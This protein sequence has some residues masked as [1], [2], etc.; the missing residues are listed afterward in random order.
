MDVF[1]KQMKERSGKKK[2]RKETFRLEFQNRK[3]IH[4]KEAAL[5]SSSVFFSVFLPSMRG[6]SSLTASFSF[7][8]LTSAV[9][10]KTRSLVD[11]FEEEEASQRKRLVL[12]FLQQ[13]SRPP[14]RPFVTEWL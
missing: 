2:E 13:E 12:P 10:F 3:R 11:R 14:W 8:A 5:S 7:P 1:Q 4:L 6:S 9:P